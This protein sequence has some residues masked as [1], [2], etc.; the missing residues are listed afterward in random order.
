M[1]GRPAQARTLAAE[2]NAR[3]IPTA[4]GGPWDRNR[5]NVFLRDGRRVRAGAAIP[6][7]GGRIGG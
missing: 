2:L 6:S 1:G 3:A 5:V 4:K 7:G